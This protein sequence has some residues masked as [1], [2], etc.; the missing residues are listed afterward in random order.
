MY[1]TDLLAIY[2]LSCSV[3]SPT[4]HDCF[5]KGALQVLKKTCDDRPSCTLK[6]SQFGDPCPG[7]QSYLYI[8]YSCIRRCEWVFLFRFI[9]NRS[10]LF[11]LF[12]TIIFKDLLKNSYNQ[13]CMYLF[14]KKCIPRVFL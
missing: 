4:S 8:K 6:A 13:R 14:V 10:F 12:Y 11:R 7:F 5:D 1:L 2:S 3:D 9:L